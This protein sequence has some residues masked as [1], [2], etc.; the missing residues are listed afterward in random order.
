MGLKQHIQPA[1]R[2]KALLQKKPKKSA[3]SITYT[4]DINCVKD[5][6]TDI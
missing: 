3:V 5:S 2:H 6:G 4:V 1:R